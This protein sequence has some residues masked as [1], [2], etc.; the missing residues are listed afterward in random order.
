MTEGDEH[1]ASTPTPVT[2]RANVMVFRFM[3]VFSKCD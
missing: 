2:T 3:G 1:P